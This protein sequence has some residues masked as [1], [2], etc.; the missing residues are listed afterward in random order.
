MNP[1]SI[2]PNKCYMD[3][4]MLD[5]STYNLKMRLKANGNTELFNDLDMSGN[6]VEQVESVY[7]NSD[8]AYVDKTPKLICRFHG[9]NARF[10]R[11][12]QGSDKHDG[13]P[14]WWWYE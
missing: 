12:L 2:A 13:V 3:F 1:V 11:T 8:K 4:Y 14:V 6:D 9:I 10:L 5:G 7:F